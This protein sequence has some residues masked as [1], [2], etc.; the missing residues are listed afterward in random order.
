[1]YVYVGYT[2]GYV[3]AFVD[4]GVVVFGSGWSYPGTA[5]AETFGAVGRG[6]GASD[7]SSAIGAA[8]GFGTPWAG[9]GGITV[10]HLL[11]EFIP[12]TGIRSGTRRT[13]LGYTT[14]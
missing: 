12:S 10:H 3:G 1:M 7:F 13:G 2:P 5:G 4:D 8:A 9:S 6:P 14:T 11:I